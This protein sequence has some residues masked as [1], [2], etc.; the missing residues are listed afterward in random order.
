VR[1]P[2]SSLKSVQFGNC[3]GNEVWS[4]HFA[5][6]GDTL[7]PPR[8]GAEREGIL[9]YNILNYLAIYLKLGCLF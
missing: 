1:Y 2:A 7:F 5:E 3:W 8:R 4:D 9:Q 6:P